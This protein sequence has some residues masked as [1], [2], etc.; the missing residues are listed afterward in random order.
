[1]AADVVLATDSAYIGSLICFDTPHDPQVE[2]A[3]SRAARLAEEWRAAQWVIA[4]N[5]KGVTP[6]SSA[7]LCYL[8]ERRIASPHRARLPSWGVA[9]S[10]AGRKTVLRLRERWGGR[11]ACL[12]P[13]A[14]VPV[15]EMQAKATTS[16]RAVV[17]ACAVISMRLR[18]RCLDRFIDAYARSRFVLQWI[19]LQLSRC[20]GS[21]FATEKRARFRCRCGV[22][23]GRAAVANSLP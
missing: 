13:H 3:R 10:P 6:S 18:Q 2:A 9:G 5:R 1:M 20:R 8:E 4:Q 21:V 19:L 17:S 11:V 23:N 22:Q 14:V 15:A 7:V 12:R 16:E